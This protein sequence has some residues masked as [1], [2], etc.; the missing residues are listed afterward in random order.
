M[1]KPIRPA[2]SDQTADHHYRSNLQRGESSLDGP[3]V[4]SQ[5]YRGFTLVMPVVVSGT[6][7]AEVRPVPEKRRV[8]RRPLDRE[9]QDGRTVWGSAGGRQL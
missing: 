1:V 6:T 3:I 4:S 7:I 2:P 5:R 9:K 8:E